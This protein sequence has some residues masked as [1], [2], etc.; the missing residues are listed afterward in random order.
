MGRI[1]RKTSVTILDGNKK[2]LPQTTIK[3]LSILA[4]QVFS[5]LQIKS[6]QKNT[7]DVEDDLRCALSQTVPRF[8]LL[9]DKKQG[10]VSHLFESLVNAFL[11]LSVILNFS[12][13]SSSRLR[14]MIIKDSEYAREGMQQKRLRSTAL[15]RCATR[16]RLLLH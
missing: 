7:L 12:S 14:L 2:V 8:R 9:S 10:Q 6:K 15:N 13:D 16:Y 4:D 3:A 11:N 5:L 1:P